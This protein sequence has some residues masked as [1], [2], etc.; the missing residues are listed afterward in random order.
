MLGGARPQYDPH[1]TRS[2]SEATDE[3]DEAQL[4]L[5]HARNKERRSAAKLFRRKEREKAR[6]E[7]MR[8]RRRTQVEEEGDA[9]FSIEDLKMEQ[10]RLARIRL[11]KAR[12][13]AALDLAQERLQ[14]QFSVFNERVAAAE[15]DCDSLEAPLPL[16]PR[17]RSQRVR[18]LKRPASE[19]EESGPRRKS[20]R[21]EADVE[22]ERLGG[23]TLDG[24]LLSLI[25]DEASSLSPSATVATVATVVRVDEE[26]QLVSFLLELGTQNMLGL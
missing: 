2:M 14:A 4:A 23:S 9:R 1:S 10:E 17:P 6:T 11:R 8:I 18:K 7:R 21:N 13:L 26:S 12:E 22:E 24:E 16:A 25:G 20:A 19:D 5:E 15:A 3:M